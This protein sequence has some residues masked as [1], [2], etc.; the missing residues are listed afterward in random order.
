MVIDSIEKEAKFFDYSDLD[1][2]FNFIHNSEILIRFLRRALYT[3]VIAFLFI[4]S[5]IIHE[6]GHAIALILTNSKFTGFSLNLHNLT[7]VTKGITYNSESRAIVAISGSLFSILI[8]TSLK[9]LL[10]FKKNPYLHL[11]LDVCILNEIL[12]W[13][14]SSIIKY[15]DAHIFLEIIKFDGIVFGFLFFVIYLFLYSLTLI[16]FTKLYERY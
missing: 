15:G 16:E 6:I 7:A 13:S 1:I 4:S 10:I 14:I 9:L 12:Y 5:I 8:F 11:S 2:V 3:S